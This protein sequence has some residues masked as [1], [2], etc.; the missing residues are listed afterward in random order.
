M[1]RYKGDPLFEMGELE[2]V[3]ILSIVLPV[4]FTLAIVLFVLWSAGPMMLGL[5]YGGTYFGIL[6]ATFTMSGWAVVLWLI[7]TE[8]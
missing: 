3:I 2:T 5:M 8:P 4:G 7:V 6:G 1:T